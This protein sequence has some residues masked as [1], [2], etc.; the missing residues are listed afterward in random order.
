MFLRLICAGIMVLPLGLMA[1]NGDGEREALARLVHELEALHPLI[2]E[3]Q[4]KSDTSSRVK[5]NYG[6]LRD[7]LAKIC[8]GV[9][10]H[11]DKPRAEPR[12]FP[13]LTGDYR[14]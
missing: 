10:S 5:F 7:D 4:A 2:E 11:I 1:D 3:A 9:Q 14:R 6:W 8:D 13:P 12:Q